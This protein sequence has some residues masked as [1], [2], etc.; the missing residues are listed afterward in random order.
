MIVP[1]LF[2]QFCRQQFGWPSQKTNFLKYA[3]RKTFLVI[4]KPKRI[5]G[6]KEII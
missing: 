2:L 6:I 3:G 5:V 1:I 4:R